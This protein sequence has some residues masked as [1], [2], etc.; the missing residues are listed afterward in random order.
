MIQS[1]ADLADELVWCATH[2][3]GDEVKFSEPVTVRGL[4]PAVTHFDVST[5]EGKRFRVTVIEQ[6]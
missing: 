6:H 1:T 2:P 3:A 5:V 4:V